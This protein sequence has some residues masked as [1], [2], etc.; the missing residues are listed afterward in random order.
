MANKRKF[1]MYLEDSEDEYYEEEHDF[2]TKEE[3]DQ[4][5][6]SILEC[7]LVCSSWNKAV[8]HCYSSSIMAGVPELIPEINM[9]PRSCV[10]RMASKSWT[11][12]FFKF[13]SS[14]NIQHFLMKF[15]QSH[16]SGIAAPGKN[17]IFG[18]W[19]NINLINEENYINR[20]TE[21]LE[22]CG[23][24][25]WYCCMSWRNSSAPIALLGLMPNLRF[26]KMKGPYYFQNDYQVNPI[27]KLEKLEVVFFDYTTT[28]VINEMLR[29]N[30][31]I[32]IFK[33][34]NHF[35]EEVEFEVGCSLT[36]LTHFSSL[37][38]RSKVNLL[39]ECGHQWKQLNKLYLEYSYKYF[40]ELESYWANTLTA[41]ELREPF[42]Y[43]DYLQK[44]KNV[45]LKLPNIR[46]LSLWMEE[47]SYLDFIEPMQGSLEHL[48]I[49]VLYL[50]SDFETE[51]KKR[52]M[53]EQ[54]IEFV[55]FEGKM[56]TKFLYCTLSHSFIN[57]IWI[58]ICIGILKNL[59]MTQHSFAHTNICT[60]QHKN[61]GIL[62]RYLNKLN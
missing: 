56:H 2:W 11:R 8:E 9:D 49:H 16:F 27:P 33:M 52:I 41:L 51:D 48:E 58:K 10:Q 42:E 43:G 29:V 57:S 22:L 59:I 12:S 25:V 37:L 4:W 62:T 35:K 44:S 32:K 13:K 17:P 31:H 39:E 61:D 3:T 34:E 36:N 53:K 21:L 24:E 50:R 18:R 30:N 5:R 23:K 28:C 38:P 26:L 20:I 47:L 54:T 15:S 14:E 7:R 46:W 40:G 45:R 6:I 1:A 60:C 19:L 55:G